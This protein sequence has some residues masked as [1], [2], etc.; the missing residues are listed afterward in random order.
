MSA[1]SA[2]RLSCPSVIHETMGDE[3][4][5][6]NLDSGRY[7]SLEGAG[8]ALWEALVAGAPLEA[9]SEAVEARFAGERAEIDSAVAAVVAELEAEG[10]IGQAAANGAAPAPSPNVGER[11]PFV[12]PVLQKY[13]DME[14][15]LL[16]DPIH[17]VDEQG[18]PQALA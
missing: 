16:L 17:E 15:L 7:Y 3:V 13:T 8:A 4:V 5:V 11:P 9:V 1:H 2:Y 14:A 10:L 12:A 18:W 6:I